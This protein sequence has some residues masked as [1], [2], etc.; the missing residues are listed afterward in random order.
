MKLLVLCDVV[1]RVGGTE[2][3]LART[4]PA[5]A[6]SGVDVTIVGRRV[7]QP[8]AFGANARE[9]AWGAD[10]EPARPEAARA[11]GRAIDELR[12]DVVMTSNVHD[13]AVMAAARAAPLLIV[14]VHDHR[15]F[16]PQG[17]RQYPHFPQL[18]TLAMSHTACLGNAVLRG[19]ASGLSARTLGLVRERLALR[20]ALQ[21]ADRFVVAS[22]FVA[23]L[24]ALN[25]VPPQRIV[26]IPPPF[27]GDP[28]GVPSPRPP[29]D[30]VLFAGRLVRDKGLESLIRAIARLPR[31]ARPTLA[32]AGAPTRESKP[33]P[34]LAR[35]LGVA[36]T[37]LGHLDAPALD[38][39][40]DAS[41]LVAVPSLWP[42]PFG[43]IGIEAQARGRP[44]VAYDVGGISEWM[45]GAGLLASRGDTE[46]LARA[47]TGVLDANRWNAFATTALAQS[48][49]FR[50]DGHVASLVDL[51]TRGRANADNRLASEG[52]L[53]SSGLLIDSR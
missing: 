41:T 25:G 34:E 10:D 21:A 39:E 33:L 32:V 23:G 14:R 46:G 26:A 42:E 9:I 18:C 49:R 22:R 5:L 8:G 35:K 51:M 20:E 44:V 27:E 12:P 30:R 15:L 50:L 43:L 29:E 40:I 45:G 1:D 52:P 24:C 19:C 13:R 6:R 38:A 2:S 7:V 31:A 17:D 48:A 11:V 16:C 37:M 28:L 47:I 53:D 4:L 36:L 3:Y